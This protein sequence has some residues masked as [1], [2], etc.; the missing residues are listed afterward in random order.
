MEYADYYPISCLHWMQIYFVFKK[1]NYQ[2]CIFILDSGNSFYLILFGLRFRHFSSFGPSRK[3][4]V[5]EP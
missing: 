4:V 3:Y 1:L 5:I 2:V